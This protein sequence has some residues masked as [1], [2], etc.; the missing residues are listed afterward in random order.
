MIPAE[1]AQS[2]A[3]ALFPISILLTTTT[4]GRQKAER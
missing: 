1:I 4:W 3:F 2:I